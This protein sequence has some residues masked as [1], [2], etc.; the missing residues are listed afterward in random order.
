MIDCGTFDET[1]IRRGVKLDNLIQ[2][3]HN[4]QIGEHTVIAAQTGI[5]GSTIIGNHCVIGGQVGIGG[6]LEVADHTQ[7]A[8]KS[9]I[10][11][12]TNP[13]QTLAGMYAFDRKDHA[14][15]YIVYRRLPEVLERLERLE[16]KLLELR[17][18]NL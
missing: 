6:H 17:T 15:S 3:A 1:I 8:A 10:T 12:D 7:A 9:G 13:N 11:K 2:I 18:P 14:R 5:S 16:K 4:V